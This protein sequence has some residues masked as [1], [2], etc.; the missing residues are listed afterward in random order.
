[1][2]H[3][4]ITGTGSYLPERI[5]T[6]AELE[7]SID[8]TDEW[9]FTRTGIRERHIVA[10]GQYTS[11][12]ALE[13]AK[14]AIEA[15]NIDIQSIDLI[16]LATTTP[17]RT[18]PS[19]ACL[20]Q[21]KLGIINCPAFDLQAVCSGFV[22][23]LATADNFI[24]AGAAKCVLVVGAD[25]MSRITDWTDRSNCILWGDGAGAVILQASNE[26]GILSTHLHANGNFADMLTVPQGVSNQEGSKTI[27][28]EGNAVFKMAVNTLDAIVDDTLAANGLEKSDIDWLVPHQ[29]NIRIL[30][31]T[32]KKLGMSM[33]RVVTTV[34][35]HGNTSAASIPLALDV[36]VRDGRIKRGETIL[37]EAFGGGFTWGSVLMK[38]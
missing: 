37:M 33:D 12:M 11:D 26:Q 23:A 34:D 5:L 14:K 36:A 2:K 17:D 4:R 20:L 30:Q 16:V 3:S 24:K 1:M 29:A 19:T 18:F 25:A 13:A 21:K 8:T 38:Y 28:M 32:A 10:E 35:K 27:L 22:Y 15:A 31:S 7:R 9:I 6:N